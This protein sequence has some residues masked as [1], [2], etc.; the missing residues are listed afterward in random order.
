MEISSKPTVKKLKIIFAVVLL[1]MLPSSCGTVFCAKQSADEVPALTILSSVPEADV[2][3][4]G[5]YVGK[6]PYSHFGDK[7]DV[8]K[9]TVKK[10]GYKSKSI[11]PRKLDQWAYVNFVP[12]PMWNWIWGYFVDRCQTKCWRYKKDV[13]YFDLKEK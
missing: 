8:R 1:S 11:K 7:V 12:W 9:I 5:K 6:T 13:F 10:D 4:N 2:Y 3:L